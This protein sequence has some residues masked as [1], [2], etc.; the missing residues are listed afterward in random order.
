MKWSNAWCLYHFY[1]FYIPFYV[2]HNCI[3]YAIRPFQAC[4][5]AYSWISVLYI[6]TNAL[7]LI[8]F[9]LILSCPLCH[10]MFTCIRHHNSSFV[11]KVYKSMV[12]TMRHTSLNFYTVKC[13][14][15]ISWC[16]HLWLCLIYL[17]VNHPTRA[18]IGD[19]QRS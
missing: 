8:W 9:V 19:Y 1:L 12:F 2:C 15:I 13:P 16:A 14:I 7:W 4:F 10:F 11:V 18:K 5:H 17:L 6:L 3:H